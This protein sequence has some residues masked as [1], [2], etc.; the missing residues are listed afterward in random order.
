M[1]ASQQCSIAFSAT[2]I[3][4]LATIWAELGPLNLAETS[5]R[6]YT[7]HVALGWLTYSATNR[8]SRYSSM[9]AS[10]SLFKHLIR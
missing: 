4:T 5:N 10:S 8:L 1:N 6:V 7:P 9:L 3:H 2:V